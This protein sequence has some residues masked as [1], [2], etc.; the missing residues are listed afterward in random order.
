MEDYSIRSEFSDIKLICHDGCLYHSRFILNRIEYF[1]NIIN[2]INTRDMDNITTIDLTDI[3][4][5]KG[6]ISMELINLFLNLLLG[7]YIEIDN[8]KVVAQCARF[9]NYINYLPNLFMHI[10]SNENIIIMFSCCPELLKD[11]CD[12]IVSMFYSNYH[13]LISRKICKGTIGSL[14]YC[15]ENKYYSLKCRTII[16]IFASCPPEKMSEYD[17]VS[18]M[19]FIDNN[20][21]HDMMCSP[22]VINILKHFNRFPKYWEWFMNSAD[23]I[24]LS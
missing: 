10:L 17:I 1:S 19:N 21:A 20:K 11:H 4:A 5:I 6:G 12:V 23:K 9:C 14:I 18:F 24:V 2:I 8:I 3:T 7:K 13:G 15:I 22:R 16:N